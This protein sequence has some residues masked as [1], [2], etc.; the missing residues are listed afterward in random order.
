MEQSLRKI[1]QVD[2]LTLG[3]SLDADLRAAAQLLEHLNQVNFGTIGTNT[4]AVLAEARTLTTSL[5][6]FVDDFHK[7][8]Q[9]MDLKRLSSNAEALIARLQTTTGE[10]DTLLS[11]IDV[12][13]INEA[14]ANIKCASL[15][16][17]NTLRELK[18]YPSGFLFGAPPA[19]AKSVLPPGK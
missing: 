2:L 14:L 17:E 13:S 10:L 19:P 12:G 4:E 8:F 7:T 11:N 1:S 18:Q 9:G 16:L 3:K 6:S 15:E 5:Q